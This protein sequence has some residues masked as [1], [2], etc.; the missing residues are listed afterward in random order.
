MLLICDTCSLVRL[1]KGGASSII[2]KLFD[3]VLIPPAVLQEIQDGGF[4]DL[5]AK[6]PFEVRHPKTILQI[7]MGAGEREAV[8]LATEH[9]GCR[10]LT[11][12]IRA[13]KKAHRLGII[14][15]STFDV[16]LLAKDAKLIGA[17]RLILDAMRE[18]REGIPQVEYESVLRRAG[19]PFGM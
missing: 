16:L 14:V 8:S 13:I 6:H 12:D 18:A 11:D 19:E 17:V 1:E 15:L 10:L 7:G 4:D 3:P 9:P 2:F 5:T